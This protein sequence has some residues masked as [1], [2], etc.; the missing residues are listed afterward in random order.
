[1]KDE[2]HTFFMDCQSTVTKNVCHVLQ[3]AVLNLVHGVRVL[4]EMSVKRTTVLLLHIL[5]NV[6]T[7]AL[8]TA[9]NY[10][11]YEFANGLI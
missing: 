3:L 11:S 1:M 6:H 4:T 5:P 10:S 2:S 8:F 7:P 9:N